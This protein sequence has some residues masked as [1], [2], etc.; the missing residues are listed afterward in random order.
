MDDVYP[1]LNVREGVGRRQDC[2]ALELLVQ[3]PVSSAV[4]REGRAVH[5]TPQVV[6]FVEV[7]YSVL[8]LVCVKVRLHVGYLD[9]GLQEGIQVSAVKNGSSGGHT[10]EM[11][12]TPSFLVV[13]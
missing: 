5:E 9:V 4:Q 8:H 12:S 3:I 2:F 1:G 13:Q 11:I 7:S 6:V 10:D